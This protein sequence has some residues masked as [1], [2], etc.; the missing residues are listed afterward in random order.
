MD[1]SWKVSVNDKKYTVLFDGKGKLYAE[2]YG[3]SW[4]DLTGDNL[5]YW[6]AVELMEARDE[7]ARLKEPA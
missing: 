5:V 6:L 4:Q 7:I 1:N 2:R 3:E